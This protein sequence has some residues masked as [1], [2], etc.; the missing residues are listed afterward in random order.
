MSQVGTDR[1]LEFQFSEGQYRLFL[2][3]YA[4]GNIVLTD[5]DLNIISLLRIVPEGTDQEELRVGLKY[6]LENRQN[7]NGV[8]PLTRARLTDALQKAE[9]SREDN[10]AVKK[11]KS[12]KNQGD[13]LRKTL[14]ASLSE[15]PPMLID[16]AM[17][18]TDFNANVT[19]RQVLENDQS[20]DNLM[21]TLAV[22]Q[23]VVKSITSSQVSKGF[24]VAKAR[25][26]SSLEVDPGAT[27]ERQNL[28]YEDFHPFRPKQF[29]GDSEIHIFESDGFN[30]TVD[31][32]FSSI[33][34]Q[35]LE[36]RLYERE[37]N[38]KKKLDM[39]RQEHEKRLGG[40]QQAQQQN[41]RK[42]EAIEANWQKVQ[43]VTTA[44][45]G[46]IAQGMDWV[47]IAR[48]I[49][50]EQDKQNPVA[51]SIKLPLKLYENTATL[52]LSEAQFEADDDYEGNETGSDVSSIEDDGP[53][54]SA[55]LRSIDDRL[56]VDIDLA[57]SPWSNARQYYDQKKTAAVKEQKTIQSSSKALKSTERKINADLKKGLKQEKEV[58]KPVRKQMWFEKFIYFIS[59]EG[60]LVL[61]GRDAQQNDILY[62]KYLK[63]GDIYVHA[64]LN[65]AASVVVK[66]K[67]RSLETP[68]P[69]STLS[70]A[71]NLAVA[72]SSAWDSKAV[73]SAWWVK[74]D[75]VSKTA[76][77]GEYLTTGDFTIRGQKNFLPP[78]QL[79]LGFGIMFQ[80]SEESKIRRMKH[81]V[82][83]I[84]L[85]V[86]G[87]SLTVA[88]DGSN[89]RSENFT[90]HGKVPTP[91]SEEA[92]G[93]LVT[94][95][96]GHE[97]RIEAEDEPDICS[98][99]E[100]KIIDAEGSDS[101]ISDH[102][103]NEARD[104]AAETF[105]EKE[106]FKRAR[107]NPLQPYS[108][109][110]HDL[111]TDS[112]AASAEEDSGEDVAQA[113]ESRRNGKDHL[114]YDQEASSSSTANANGV[115]SIRH[116]S[117]KERRLLRQNRFDDLQPQQT[118]TSLPPRKDDGNQSKP[119]HMTNHIGPSAQIKLQA[120][121]VRG[122]HGKRNKIKTKYAD[123]DDEDRLL[124][125]QVLGSVTGQQKVAGEAEIKAAKEMEL[126]AQ[127]ERRRRQHALVAEQGKEA[128][129][130]REINM[131]EGIETLS[132]EEMED[133]GD[134]DTFVG[135]VLPGDEI[136]DALVVCG[137]WDAIGGRCKWRA[138]LQPGT[139][140]KGK[141]VREILGAWTTAITDKDRKARPPTAAVDEAVEAEEKTIRREKDLVKGIREQEVIGLLPVSKCKITVARGE[142]N[143]GK[144]TG[145][146]SKGKRGGKGGKKQR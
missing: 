110:R 133:Y 112:D 91:T 131:Q 128:E 100:D 92:Q 16:H 50:M 132:D 56:A 123:Q 105:H 104:V 97:G 52:L 107:S 85:S 14:S 113:E 134:L 65:G 121:P 2:E 144:G 20:L 120:L 29:E 94:D 44:I 140:K 46:L 26:S 36:S 54:N 126:A 23:E 82:G 116:L 66:N 80:I 58:M 59:S 81:R 4:G 5:K 15:L 24:I 19:P 86:V 49:E 125:L 61:G 39:A 64:D 87:S 68:I 6:R 53:L 38:A 99:D 21:H 22:A 95:E 73:M 76:P 41:V 33:E 89:A 7:Y 88:E 35:K 142:G 40:L 18:L 122:K 69:P 43:E 42:A 96:A 139:T 27:I 32:F 90:N 75:Q 127:K 72:T 117:A 103:E 118:H 55:A 11:K 138:K 135:T 102:S 12:R 106:P 63:K 93:G 108:E 83:E 145:G 48:L 136:L 78:T 84:G 109:E 47:E 146:A 3:F 141:A 9:L 13:S 62:K 60:Y 77:T 130:I 129:E 98:L 70:Q 51:D 8:P 74:A 25:S 115:P 10:Q 111:S 17:Q 101:N 37:E 34:S 30:K 143:Q 79:L 45:N 28:V 67:A 1:V 57:L 124:A 119:S 31:E 71:G 137:P 114:Y